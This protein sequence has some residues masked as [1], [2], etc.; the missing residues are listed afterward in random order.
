MRYRPAVLCVLGLPALL[1]TLCSTLGQDRIAAPAPEAAQ[2]AP[3]DDPPKPPPSTTVE[4]SFPSKGPMESAWK[5][6]WETKSGYGLIIKNAHFKRGPGE[7]W[8]QVLG[9]ARVSEIFVPYHRGEPRFWDV[10]YGFDLTPMTDADRGPTGKLHVSHNGSGEVPC[11]V[12]ELRDRGIM[13]KSGDKV[14]RGEVLILWGC[15]SAAN[16]RY[17]MEYGFQDDG[18][19]S[20]RLGSTGHNFSGSEWDPHMHNALWRVQVNLGGPKNNVYLMEIIETAS[21]GGKAETKHTPFN[22]NVEG[23][24][25]WNPAKFTMLRV[26]NEKLKNAQGKPC[27]Y[28][29]MPQRMGTARHFGGDR[30]QREENCTL[31]DFWVTRA[32]ADELNYTKLPQYV[33]DKESIK[34]ADVVLWYSSPMHHEPRSEDGEIVDGQIE[35]CTHVAWSTFYLRPSNIFDRTPFYPYAKKEGEK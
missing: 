15:L 26:V 24:A 4:R 12:E 28:D 34:D 7:P 14:R 25:D 23:Y 22:K 21:G 19:I 17:I 16:Y 30:E 6:E 5:V 9:D 2:P 13:W 8:L 18:T 1:A 32:K 35:G 3:K 11:V 27:S 33:A 31:H 10:S 20:F 29:L